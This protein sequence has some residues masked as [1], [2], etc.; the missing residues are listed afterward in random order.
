VET[1]EKNQELVFVPPEDRLDL[2]GLLWICHKHLCRDIGQYRYD[3][4]A[5]MVDLEHMECLEL[6]VLALI[7]KEVHHHLQV[8]FVGNVAGHNVEICPIEQ[9]L[10][11]EL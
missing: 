11:Q 3:D 7:S 10:A 4:D 1:L 6:D 2:R 5:S 9:D 8:G